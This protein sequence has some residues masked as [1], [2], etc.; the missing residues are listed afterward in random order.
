MNKKE[1]IEFERLKKENEI[2]RKDILNSS[3]Q[4]LLENLDKEYWIISIFKLINILI[5]NEIEQESY[6]KK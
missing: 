6:W 2:I 3:N 1:Q 5:N 4:I